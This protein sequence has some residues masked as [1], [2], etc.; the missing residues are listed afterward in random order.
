MVAIGVAAVGSLALMLYHAD[1]QLWI[2]FACAAAYDLAI[3]WP[4]LRVVCARTSNV[5]RRAKVDP[6]VS[7]AEKH[8]KRPFWA[9]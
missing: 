5:R 3:F 9:R 2:V 1:R 4:M 6:A 8:Q 7:I